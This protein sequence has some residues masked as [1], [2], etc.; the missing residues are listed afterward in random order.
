[1]AL[2]S[3][4]YTRSAFPV[5]D[6][7]QSLSA[8]ASNDAGGTVITYTTTGAHNLA[9]G[10]VVVTKGFTP[11]TYPWLQFDPDNSVGNA[12]PAVVASVTSSTVFTV[13]Y[14]STI[15]TA[16]SSISGTVIQSAKV[17]IAPWSENWLPTTAQKNVVVAR[18]WGNSF[19]IQPNKESTDGDLRTQVTALN[20]NPTS[21]G[22]RVTYP[23]ASHSFVAGQF[24]NIQ[25]VV[26]D[27]YNLE[28]VQIAATTSTTIV[29]NSTN[30]ATVTSTAN[31]GIIAQLRLGGSQAK[32][33]AA[34][35]PVGATSPTQ[36]TNASTGAIS[37]TVATINVTSTTSPALSV[38]MGVTSGSVF[39]TGTVVTAIG[40]GT[41][42]V[43]PLP[44]ATAAAGTTLTFSSSLNNQYTTA[45]PHNLTNGQTVSVKGANNSS[46]NVTGIVNVVNS[47]VFSV[48]APSFRIVKVSATDGTGVVGGA[49]NTLYYTDSAHGLAAGDKVSVYGIK[50]TTNTAGTANTGYNVNNAT[51]AA[52]PAPTANTF[53]LAVGNTTTVTGLGFAVKSGPVFTAP[54]YVSLGDNGW[55]STYV[56]PSGYL[57]STL[58]NH[59]RV[60]NSDSGFPAFAPGIVVP[61]LKGLTTTN[62]IQKLR[63]VGLN[64]GT[65]TFTAD[66]TVSAA[67]QDG[68]GWKFTTGSTPHYLGV[69][70][71]VNLSGGTT[72]AKDNNL[73]DTVVSAVAGYTFTIGNVTGTTAVTN[74]VARPKNTVV[75]AQTPNAGSTIADGSAKSV[76]ITR[77]YG[78]GL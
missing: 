16:A 56:S 69:G 27:I 37:T 44:I 18:E 45:L 12:N 72:T 25:G 17:D 29:V 19:P 62:A 48:P 20:G 59:D 10:Q 42:T 76:F 65:T 55:N 30:T 31:A 78:L 38:G 67:V 35:G 5:T 73:G 6:T 11:G 14:P 39:A 75:S 51:V 23:V 43:N 66:L 15:T 1:M 57:V 77:N 70:D 3:G 68:T 34:T 13:K 7:V 24:I 32:I 8:T 33:S 60:T 58:D 22:A 52:S 47:T 40:S 2:D 53:A 26:P 49:S 50:D 61:D 4:S 9:P 28:G 71:T 74:L 36:T 21:D 46:Y 41:I 63:A 64:P 54:A